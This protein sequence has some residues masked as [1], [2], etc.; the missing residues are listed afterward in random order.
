MILT[1]DNVEYAKV[2]PGIEREKTIREN[3][4]IDPPLDH[5][6]SKEQIEAESAASTPST[7]AKLSSRNSAP[8]PISVTPNRA[9]I[10]LQQ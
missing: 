2:S 4:N 9:G 6:S 7:A 8:T 10:A 3:Q 5:D 1:T